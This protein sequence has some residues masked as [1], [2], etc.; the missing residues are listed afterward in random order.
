[1]SATWMQSDSKEEERM[2]WG[3]GSGRFVGGCRGSAA[4]Q[5][6]IRHDEKLG[7]RDVE[8]GR[9]RRK[10]GW[11]A[12]LDRRRISREGTELTGTLYWAA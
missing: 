5:E 10:E 2:M 4:G 3:K 8:H 6:M 7:F 11:E 12:T 1:M 9:H